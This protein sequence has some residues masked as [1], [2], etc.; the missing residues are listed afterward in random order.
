VKQLAATGTLCHAQ[1]V[2]E[3]HACQTLLQAVGSGNLINMITFF[4]NLQTLKTD[5]VFLI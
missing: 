1:S 3:V 4:G 5:G 2:S